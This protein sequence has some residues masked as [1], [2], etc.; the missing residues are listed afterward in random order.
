[1]ALIAGPGSRNQMTTVHSVDCECCGLSYNNGGGWRPELWASF[2]HVCGKR[3]H[4]RALPC[5]RPVAHS[6]CCEVLER[7]RHDGGGE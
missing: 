1:M 7:A 5:R 3:A 4:S 6:G 2:P